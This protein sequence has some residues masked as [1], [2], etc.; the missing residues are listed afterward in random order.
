MALL[1]ILQFPDPRL[2]KVAQP[3]TVFDLDLRRLVDD[4]YETMYE[5]KGVGLAGT[6]V[7]IHKQIFTLDIS[8]EHNQP[9]VVIN[10]EIVSAEGELPDSAEGCLSVPGVYDH[11]HRAAKVHMRGVDLDGKPFEWHAEGFL[12]HVIQHE[13]DHLNGKL[14]INHLSRLKQ[15]RIRKKVTKFQK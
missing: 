14:F 11:V 13:V 12:A 4:M 2:Q 15:E 9:Q 10:P 1:E 7:N 8:E 6:Q 3:I 5:N